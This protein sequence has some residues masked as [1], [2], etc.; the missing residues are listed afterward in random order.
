MNNRLLFFSFLLYLPCINYAFKFSSVLKEVNIGHYGTTLYSYVRDETFEE[1]RLSITDISHW[2]ERRNL[3]R[4]RGLVEN[5]L[6][7]LLLQYSNEEQQNEAQVALSMMFEL[8]QRWAF[9]YCIQITLSL[10]PNSKSVASTYFLRNLDTY[11][12][13]L[14]G[15]GLATADTINILLSDAVRRSNIR[16]ADHTF[17]LFFI[18]S[19][20]SYSGSFEGSGLVVPTVRSINI[21]MEAHRRYAESSTS[22]SDYGAKKS[23]S[24]RSDSTVFDETDRLEDRNVGIEKD[25]RMV[26]YY[27]SLFASS[28]GAIW[29]S[30][31]GAL[32]TAPLCRSHLRPD[33]YTLS[34]LVRISS[35]PEEIVALLTQNPIA[36][37]PP[38]LRCAIESLGNLGDPSAALMLFLQQQQRLKQTSSDSYPNSLPVGRKTGDAIITALLSCPSHRLNLTMTF[39]E[40]LCGKLSADA[41]IEL[42]FDGQCEESKYCIRCSSK[43]YTLLFTHIQRSLRRLFEPASFSPREADHVEESEISQRLRLA[44]A[45]NLRKNRNR[46]FEYMKREIIAEYSSSKENRTE[47]QEDTKRSLTAD[48]DDENPAVELN[49]RLVDALVRLIEDFVFEFVHNSVFLCRFEATNVKILMRRGSSGSGVCCR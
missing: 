46:L 47:H 43:G 8:L 5:T 4:V 49:S 25:Y 22:A 27:Y 29:S 16:R 42:L 23:W 20:S 2:Y 6:Y 34:T 13:N 33:C 38:V 40:D 41:A 21:M 44:A 14:A 26:R 45:A 18:S 48:A 9:N 35:Q 10:F 11:L 17:E 31:E 7:P 37:T 24:S 1:F 15:Q 32:T 19:N 3:P 36:V 39:A 12:V 28:N 30:H